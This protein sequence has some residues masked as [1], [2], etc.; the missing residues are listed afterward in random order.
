MSL[1][2]CSSEVGVFADSA[3]CV[4]QHHA[5]PKVCPSNTAWASSLAAARC[6]DLSVQFTGLVS[7]LHVTGIAPEGSSVAS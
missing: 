4:L 7:S 6:R 3:A 2:A 5:K 1:H